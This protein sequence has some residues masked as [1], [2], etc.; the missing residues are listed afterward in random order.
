LIARS[1]VSKSPLANHARVEGSVFVVE[2]KHSDK[3]YNAA[4][5]VFGDLVAPAK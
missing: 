1:A 2:I 5:G 3:S 4:T